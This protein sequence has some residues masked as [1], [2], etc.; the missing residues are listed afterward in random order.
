MICH[1][2]SQSPSMQATRNFRNLPLQLAFPISQLR[3]KIEELFTQS[4]SFHLSSK[5]LWRCSGHEASFIVARE[6]VII[7]LLQ[8]QTHPA[9]LSMNLHGCDRILLLVLGRLCYISLLMGMLLLTHK[10]KCLCL[11]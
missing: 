6:L 7:F 4:N 9:A 1:Y 5:S 3:D 8:A 2:K 11:Y 10:Q